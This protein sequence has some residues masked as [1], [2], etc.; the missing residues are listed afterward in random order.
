MKKTNRDPSFFLNVNNTIHTVQSNHQRHRTV[1]QRKN[2]R[3]ITLSVRS[4]N[5]HPFAS[6]YNSTFPK[7]AFSHSKHTLSLSHS[8]SHSHSTPSDRVTLRRRL[9][10]PRQNSHISHFRSPDLRYLVSF[11][12]IH[13]FSAWL[14]RNL[15]RVKE[16]IVE[17]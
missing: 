6:L 2:A 1:Q 9:P 11:S 15:K 8:H 17:D 10:E 16:K 3:E 13:F 4:S 5:P 12:A 14:L 7:L